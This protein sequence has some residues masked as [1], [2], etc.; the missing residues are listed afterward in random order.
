MIK[1]F[2]DNLKLPSYRIKQ[3]NKQFYQ[4]AISSWNELTTWPKELRDKLEKEV[5]FSKLKNIKE[6][7]SKDQRSIKILAETKDGHPV[8]SVLMYNKQKDRITICVSCMSGCSVGCKFCATGQMGLNTMLGSQEIIDQVMYFKRKLRNEGENIS[9]IV[10][11]GM[12][13]PML[14]LEGILKSIEILTDENKLALSPRRITVSTVGYIKQ[15]REF[16]S[17]RTR[18]KI[19][20]SLHAPNQELREELMPTVAKDNTLPELLSLMSEFEEDTNKR[21][22]YEYILLK[23]VN[24]TLEHANQLA[25]ILKDKLVL[26]N[27]INFNPSPSLPFES[28]TRERISKFKEVL[29]RNGINTTL[30][31]SMGDEI[32]GACGQLSAKNK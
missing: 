11:M 10:F 14:N 19:A 28:S 32:Q 29:E 13:E 3:F 1:E 17:K 8:E 26:V 6:Y 20:I 12:G 16:L 25:E 15:L 22:T 7:V 30:R 21:V 18:V 4:E 24:D 31:Y 27:L 23:D 5:E 2:S 9:N